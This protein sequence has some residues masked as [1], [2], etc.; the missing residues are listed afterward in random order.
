MQQNLFIMLKFAEYPQIVE[1][2]LKYSKFN[3][4]IM[5]QNVE[6]FYKSCKLE[7]IS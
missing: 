1:F 6:L 3:D 7:L 2:H 4:I 5:L